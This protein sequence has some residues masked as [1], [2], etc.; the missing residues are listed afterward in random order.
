MLIIPIKDGENIDRALKRYKRKFDKT[1][2][3]RQLR[4]RQAFIKPS[5]VKRA[6]VQKAQYI[7]TLRDSVEM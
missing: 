5:I 3:V 6:Q 1:G 2:T 7:Q 4:A